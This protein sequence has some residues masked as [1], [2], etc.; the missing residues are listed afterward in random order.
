ML[1]QLDPIAISMRMAMLFHLQEW[2][3][4]TPK[5]SAL[6]YKLAEARNEYNFNSGLHLHTWDV[7]APK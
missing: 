3:K 7:P 4:E 2:I 6:K 1:N 5:D